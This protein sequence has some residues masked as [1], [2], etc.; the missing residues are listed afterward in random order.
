M[1]LINQVEQNKD[2]QVEIKKVKNL[3]R[4]AK[5]KE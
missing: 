2:V 3:L 5:S 4:S 1:V